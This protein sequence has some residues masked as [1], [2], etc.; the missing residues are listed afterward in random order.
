MTPVLQASDLVVEYV[1]KKERVRA[2]D[3]ASLRVNTGEIVGVVGESGSGK[4]TIGAALAGA[5]DSPAQLLEGE[6]LIDGVRT[7]ELS[8]VELAELRRSKL[9]AV[10]Q[11]PIGTMDPTAKVGR[12]IR[13]ALQRRLSDSEMGQLLAEVHLQPDVANAYPHQL[14]GGMAQRVSIALALAHEPAAVIADEPTASLD[15]SIR[16]EI[17]ELLVGRARERNTAVVVIT[18]DLASVRRSCDRVVVFYGGRAVEE[19][20]TTTLFEDPKH[21]Y[22]RALL[23]SALG[24]EHPGEVVL[25]IQGQPPLL[26]GAHPG[27]AFSGRC[28]SEL[29]FCSSVRPEHR[30]VGGA[31]VLCHLYDALP[32]VPSTGTGSSKA[33]SRG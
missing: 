26:R 11:D 3:H 32:P 15:A 16:L 33:A 31:D 19:S 12:Q 2:L 25:P 10:F 24:R 14:S 20:S 29:E 28:P 1:T 7:T 23:G 4:S 6:V 18:H 17:L 13:W 8:D 5:L 22:T 30:Q 21:P 9:G 27:C